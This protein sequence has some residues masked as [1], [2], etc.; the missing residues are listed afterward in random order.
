MFSFCLV[1]ILK[2]YNEI[3]FEFICYGIFYVSCCFSCIMK[4]SLNLFAM[5]YFMCHVVLVVLK[6]NTVELLS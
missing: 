4:F 6:Y 1:Y 3:Q 2:E 5:V